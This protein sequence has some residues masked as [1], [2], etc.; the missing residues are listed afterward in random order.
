MQSDNTNQN[1]NT[2]DVSHNEKSLRIG[3]LHKALHLLG[4]HVDKE[5]EE[6]NLA[7]E[8]T[9]KQVRL[10]QERMNIPVNDAV[11]IDNETFKALIE[12]SGAQLTLAGKSLSLS[13]TVYE[14][15]GEVSKSRHVIALGVGLKGAAYYRKAKSLKEILKKGGL[16]NLGEAYTDS[17]GQYTIKTIDYRTEAN[18]RKKTDLVVFAVDG[19][20]I[21]GRSQLI[22]P[23]PSR[24]SGIIGNVDI[25]I[26]VISSKTEYELLMKTLNNYLKINKANLSDLA[27]SHD[28]VLY[29]AGELNEKYLNVRIVAKAR[30]LA[31][32]MS[33]ELLYGL[34]RQKIPFDL[35]ALYKKNDTQLKKAIDR[36]IR[37]NLIKPYDREE[38]DSFINKLRE[39]ATNHLLQQKNSKGQFSLDEILSV[40]LPEQNHRV[41]FV[42][43]VQ[44]FKATGSNAKKLD[45]GKFWNEYLPALPSF[46]RNPDLVNRLL[47]TQ[48]LAV[49]SGGHLP[50]IKEFQDNH[51]YTK[52]EELLKLDTKTLTDIFTKT[53]VPDFI[54]ADTEKNRVL[55]YVERFEN[56]INSA[57][58]T[59]KISTM[60]KNNRIPLKN[61]STANGLKTFLDIAEKFDIS[62]SRIHDFEKEIKEAVPE[63]FEAVKNELKRMQR[64]F[65]VSTSPQVMAALMKNDLD[66]AYKIASIPRKSFLKMYSN[67]L[68]GPQTADAV[69]QRST[70]ISTRAAEQAIK[71]YD[72]SHSEAP[73]FAYSGDDYNKTMAVLQRNV[74]NYSELFGSPDI[75]ECDEGRSV[76]SASA[77]L[78]D[79]LRFL[80]R[81][82]KNHDGKSPLDI[83]KERRPDLL[84]LP[85]TSENTNTIIPYIDLV[86]EVMEYY[87]YHGSLDQNTAYDTGDTF[88]DELRASPQNFELEAYRILKKAVYPFS[89]PYHQPLDVIRTYGRHLGTERF[90]IMNVF[91]GSSSANSVRAYQA[92]VL[93]M[94]QEEYAIITG[95]KFDNSNDTINL[96]EDYGYNSHSDLEKLA[97]TGIK[98]GIHEF[99]RRSGINYTD[100]VELLKTNFINP[101]QSI[102]DWLEEL[103]SDSSLGGKTLYSKLQKINY[104]TLLP[105]SD[106]EIMTALNQAK[107]SA[108]DFTA[109]VKANFSNFNSIITLY[110]SKS[111]CDL[112]TTYLRTIGNVYASA[113]T[114]GI[115][116]VTWSKIHRFLR[117]WKK[118]GWTIHETA[119]VLDVLGERDTHGIVD[120]TQ[121]TLSRISSAVMLNRDLK[122]PVN[123][124]ATLWGNIDS[125]GKK[126]LYKKLF[127]NKAVQRIDT[128]FEPDGFGNFLTDKNAKLKDHIPAILAAFRMSGDDLDSIIDVS[129][130]IENMVSRPLRLDN[131][132]LNI[133]NLSTIYRYTVLAKALK[134]KVPDFCLLVELFIKKPFSIFSNDT[135]LFTNI[136]PSLTLNF[137]KMAQQIK[138]SGFK[139]EVLQYIF[140]GILPSGSTTNL[141]LN[142][143]KVKTAARQIREELDAIEQNFP[144]VPAAP[145]TSGILSDILSL[146]YDADIVSS[147]IGIVESVQSYQVLTDTDL[148]IAI[149]QLMTQKYSYDPA[150]GILTSK[151]SMTNADKTA[152]KSLPGSNDSF[153]SAVDKLYTLSRTNISG[154]PMYT[155]MT[156]ANLTVT[157][158]E[159]LSAKFSYTKASGR[160]SCT[161]IMS[162]SERTELINLQGADSN[163]NSAVNS[164]YTMPEDFIVKNF[165]K[166][167]KDMNSTKSILLNHPAQTV[168]AA[169]EEKLGFVYSSYLP[170]L[171]RKL[172]ED[173]II[174]HI[175]SLTGTVEEAVSILV[176]ED[177]ESLIASI[178]QQG[179]SAQYFSDSTFTNADKSAVDGSLN[180]NWGNKT[181]GSSRW[182]AYLTSPS[183][184]EYTLTV[185]VLKPDET[186]KLYLDNTLI[187]EKPANNTQTSWEVIVQLNSSL[188]HAIMLECSI[189]S[190]D[191]GVKLSW[192]S[193]TSQ[194]ETVPSGAVYPKNVID[195]FIDSMTVYH[196]AV[197][198]ITGFKLTGQEIQHFK[199]YGKDFDNID[200]KAITPVHWIRFNNYVQL[201]NS[202]PQAKALLTDVFK[203]ANISNPAPVITDI[204]GKLCLATAWDFDTVSYLSGSCF[205]LGIGDFKNEISISKLFS[206]LKY[207]NS[208]G[209]PV[210][211]IIQWAAP[212]TDFD[213]LNICAELVK[214]AVKAKYESDDWMKIAGG[215]SDKIRE[216]QKQALIDNLL[217][218]QKLIDWGVKDA[219]GLFEYF[220]IDVQMTPCMDTSR[221][222]QANSSVQLFV[223]RCLLNL[224][225]DKTTGFEKGAAPDCIDRDRWEWMKNYRVWEANRKIFLYPENW[226]E[227]E[228]RDDRSPFFKDLESELIQNDIT[229]QSVETA[230]RNYL[231]KLN[232]VA[233]LDVWG[234]YQENDD[235]GAFK[236]L[237]VFARSHNAPYQFYYRTWNKY[238]KWSAWEKIQTDIRCIDD[239]DNSGV[240]LIPVVWKKR[241]FLFWPEYIQKQETNT[242]KKDGSSED[243]SFVDVSKKPT[244][245]LK[246][247]DYWEIRLAWSENQNGKWS[248]KQLTKEFI[249][250]DGSTLPKELSF[251]TYIDKSTSRLDIGIRMKYKYFGE[252][253]VYSDTSNSDGD[254]YSDYSYKETLTAYGKTFGGFSLSDIQAKVQILDTDYYISLFEDYY[255]N[256]FMKQQNN[257]ILE[258][259]GKT[260]LGAV[261][262]H[263]LLNSNNLFNFINSSLVNPFFYS[264]SHRT[265]FV[266]PVDVKIQDVVKDPGKSEPF[267]PDIVEPEYTEPVHEIG[268]DDYIPDP[269]DEGVIINEYDVYDPVNVATNTNIE[270]AASDSSLVDA[271]IVY[272]A[273]E[274]ANA[275]VATANY[276]PETA[277]KVMSYNTSKE[278]Q[279]FGAGMTQMYIQQSNRKIANYSTVEKAFGGNYGDP[280][281][282]QGGWHYEKG[283][284]FHTFYHPYSSQYVTNMNNCELPIK[285]LQDSD[286]SIPGDNGATFNTYGPDSTYVPVPA[287]FASRTY[288]KEN[289][290]FDALGANS[291]YNW[292]LFFHAP[293]YIATR[294]SR[295]G[296]YEEAMKWFHYIFDPTTDQ[297]PRP[298]QSDTSRYWNVLPFKTTP[299]QSLEYWFTSLLPNKNPSSENSQIGEWRDN[300]FKPHLVARDRPLAYMKNVVIKY[301]E[302]L[303]SWGDSLFTMDTMESVNEALQIYVIAS[304][305]LGPRPQFVPKRGDVKAE[306]YDSLKDKWDDF[307]NALVEMENIFPYS[308][309]VPVGSGN[310]PSSLLGIGPALYFCIPSNDRLLEYWGTVEDRLYKI[311]HCLNI[312]GVERHLA[313]FSPPIDPGALVKAAAQGLSLGSILADLSSP[314]PL[315]R[316]SYLIKQANDFCNDVKTLGNILI[317]VLE[318]KDAE[319][320]S[321]LRAS[322]ESSVLELMTQ[323]KERQI[324]DAK[325]V[326]EGLQKSRDAAELRLHHYNGL[327]S[328]QD[329]TVPA[330]PVIGSDLNADSELP[331]DTSI[332]EIKMDV[333]DS[334]TDSG[335]SGVKIINKE[336]EDLEKA[337]KAII[338]QE[339]ASGIEGLAGLLHLIPDFKASAEPMGVGACISYGGSNIG[340]G[341]SG[342]AKV[343]MIVASV[344]THQGAQAAKTA[345]FIR[346]EQEWTLATNLAAKEIIQLDKQVT[347]AD[348][349]VQIA[350]KE[351]E[352]H[353]K[354]IDNAKSIEQFLQ[355]KFTGLELYQWMK[356]QLF[357]VYKQ[358]YNMA[359]DLAKKAEKSYRFETGKEITNFIQYGY[360]DNTKQ[361]LTSGDKLQAA[362]RNMEKSYTEENRREYEIIKH[363]SIA[364]LNPL[365]LLELKTSGKC[366]LTLPEEFYDLDYQGHYF[367]RIKSVSLSIPCV[368]GPYTSVNCTLRLLKNTI[369]TKTIMNE[370]GNYEHNNDEGVWVEDSRFRDSNVPV[371]AIV[372]ST[373][374][375]DPGMFVLNFKDEQYLPFEGAGAIS[376]WKI[377]LTQDTQLRQ[378][379]YSTISDVILHISYTAREDAGLFRE[380]AI[381]HLKEL[382]TNAAELSTQPLMRMFNIK[383][384]FTNEWFRFLNPSVTGAD[385]LLSLTIRKDNFPF[386]VH[387]RDISVKRIDVL[388]NGSRQG[389]Y[390]MLM[391]CTDLDTNPMNSSEITMYQ[392]ATFANMQRTSLT[393]SPAN[394]NIE[395]IDLFS[396]LSMKFRYNSETQYNKIA[397]NPEEISDMYI[398]VHYSLNN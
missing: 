132:L 355:D 309:A 30:E 97:G 58:P 214:N 79:M 252:F 313:L 108:N 10:F 112:D 181:S 212:E 178:N 19:D 372:S 305:I 47:F 276:A 377:E 32:H 247:T 8:S 64:S 215:L 117:L 125:Y 146:S 235:V 325:A 93:G 303:I 120:I 72:L 265:Y 317:S 155:V 383:Q 95:K 129:S 298:G 17:K 364:L 223:E 396:Q 25:R 382:L 141:G 56:L 262:D 363:V 371:K 347:A 340:S 158:P 270:Y 256:Y 314:P 259:K 260:Y 237:H 280:G 106:S 324:L 333:D 162:D 369:R 197:R 202:V 327:L 366:F 28:Q 322:Q 150:S 352:V 23:G 243:A 98:D 36:S 102:L 193:A 288:Y 113:G 358:S 24:S 209:I 110:Q 184:G 83:F 334:L 287:D 310:A 115:Q 15:T 284:E 227:P 249:R 226:L 339:V 91:A 391:S 176:K 136:D 138:S 119:L 380:K 306:T 65:Q 185:D 87:T 192:K 92:E 217:T 290:C 43:A 4:F 114:S 35:A 14:S 111:R 238:M 42:N 16:D 337:K 161:G 152:L 315:Y 326:R 160:L 308:S 26:T 94:S 131:D 329:I 5:E 80:W 359:F 142:I 61:A 137:E 356:E 109:W 390:K 103:F 206:A 320:L 45:Y 179:F 187:L 159:S 104:G 198:F 267:I 70:F 46:K 148:S 74:P 232:D 218:N 271:S 164:L 38:I 258:F 231:T 286:T 189:F 20:S 39:R 54:K 167:F 57:F 188:L 393:G 128:A 300:P 220:L 370:D 76:Y 233:N 196:R 224:E 177:L 336:K 153:N 331:A 211:T 207:V 18:V 240:H 62:T 31:P 397:S 173:A 349:K 321:R 245:S 151:G 225:S 122:C 116:D 139:A 99:L 170:L 251:Y 234:I 295:N 118:L 242:P 59:Q 398:V 175:A 222:V 51:K 199:F 367:R 171:K 53:G 3:L 307:S 312:A 299:N 204:L 219:N 374:Q 272:S 282:Y 85:L 368:A 22:N 75:C 279:N 195:S 384:E 140:T 100:F 263:K 221:I 67:S 344:Y 291:L 186:F 348:I 213:K 261:V 13:G 264:D 194:I 127:L 304:H 228:W 73:G 105:S 289:V 126:S 389:D 381:S 241:L 82:V 147:L 350:Q 180:Y 354:Q 345:G 296:K 342:L 134:I 239:G 77:Y 378:F 66:S 376:A 124:L 37:N 44:S 172:H 281:I 81:G 365:A 373:G 394:M 341:V 96:W 297:M 332:P 50:L 278:G 200:F 275:A 246:A 69:H 165:D 163:F 169:L 52:A 7:S 285:G 335:E 156:K 1:L 149:P 293:L 253:P 236:L 182:E 392:D 229:D 244:S 135:K 205:N 273:S 9:L 203:S 21:L 353:E 269:V 183:T 11:I 360:W 230:F 68:G 311:R 166:V 385:Q 316:F 90:E 41:A 78:V 319:E 301:V 201:R 55:K 343:P 338:Y 40:P 362:L 33:H 388:I 144:D 257:S 274:M 277:V 89:L 283:L 330:S 294:L 248:P 216:N 133:S 60:L 268:P 328:S 6:R 27:R 357:A 387:N 12:K 174:Q 266:R 351:L 145:L 191:S 292:E 63:N 154:S 34:G 210:K 130:V 302:N 101:Y 386:F 157:I 71:M 123:Q 121:L 318:K 168:E 107:I 29:T 379:D 2:G 88:A 323:V 190:Q 346:R 86:N 250:V 375:H 255:Q 395:N 254:S 48:Q 49:L 361:G 208:T 143:D 84:Y